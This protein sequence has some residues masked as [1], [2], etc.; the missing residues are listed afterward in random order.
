MPY[1][2]SGRSAGIAA[3]LGGVEV[4]ADGNYGASITNSAADLV[5]F[6]FRNHLKSREVEFGNVRWVYRDTDNHWDE[7]IPRQL[8]C[9]ED[10]SVSFRPLVERTFNGVTALLSSEGM[11]VSQMD[12]EAAQSILSVSEGINRRRG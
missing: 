5:A 12:G 7:I 6:I 4:K 9:H 2:A 10:C 1:N 8:S 3:I 11:P